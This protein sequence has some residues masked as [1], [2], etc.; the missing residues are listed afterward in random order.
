[1][2]R[3]EDLDLVTGRAAFVADLPLPD[4]CL[5]AGF[6][7]STMAHATIDR[8][9]PGPAREADGV[10]VVET[11]DSLPLRPIVVAA[12][13]QAWSKPPLAVDVVRQIGEALAVVVAETPAQVADAVEL[14]DVELDAL[15]PVVDP[16]G[17][18]LYRDADLYLAPMDSDDA[19]P[20]AEAQETFELR[21]ANPRLASAPLECDG[22]LVVPGEDRLDVWC[23]SQGVQDYRNQLAATLEMA[24]ERLRV[25][26]PAVGGGFGGRGSLPPEFV[27]VVAL[28]ERL[29]RPIRW[30]QSRYENLTGMPQGR[31][32]ETT[33]RA[34]LDQ[35]G[36]LHGLDVDITADGG[37]SG[38][39]SPLLLIS[40]KRQVPG[41]YRWGPYR[42]TARTGLTNTAPVGA[43]RGA[44]QPEA[45]HARERLL[46]HISRVQG[47]DPIDF[48]RRRLARA[49]EFP[50]DTEGGFA[51]DQGDPVR[52]L[53]TAVELAQVEHWRRV[54]SERRAAGSTIEVGIGLANY[55]Q[56]SG[57][58]GP[59]DSAIVRIEADGTVVVHCASPDHGQ[60]HL[61]T[62]ADLVADRLG[63]DPSLVSVVDADTDGVE[64]GQSTGGSRSTQVAATVIVNAC[65]DLVDTGRERAAEELEASVDDVVVVAA[66]HGLGAGLA[67][68]GVPTRRVTWAALASSEASGCLDASRYESLA[69]AAYPYGTHV[70]I[71]EVD[72]ETGATRLVQHTA[73]DDCG[74]VLQ[75][76]LVEGQQHGGSVAGIGQALFE[77]IGHDADGNPLTATFSSYLLPA[78]SEL[79]ELQTATLGV[80]AEGNPL[81]TRGIGENGCNGATAAVHNAVI[82]ALWPRGVEHID[83]PLTPERIWQAVNASRRG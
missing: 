40:A 61:T 11:G 14:V 46:D 79:G 19:D 69:D 59:A 16:G 6:V 63:I 62:W 18:A 37:S 21:V 48:R 35:S 29:G 22:I 34:G 64:V 23:T 43:Y 54:Q 55:A 33:I 56:T 42:F 1:M 25:R 45:N 74:V 60:G 78:A 24:P 82:D 49:D 66:S 20:T 39:L 76:V 75:P 77:W 32:Y 5:H 31:G 36:R 9:D 12:Q 41:L 67:V 47:E 65:Q 44:G 28:A 50:F 30:I 52:A 57:R 2:T 71:V 27:V 83:L 70:S 58:G 53:D 8:I 17:A 26:S 13:L 10:V 15:P 38:H 80:P 3:R 73:V 4:G 7:R 81:G 72:V 68:V 51:Y